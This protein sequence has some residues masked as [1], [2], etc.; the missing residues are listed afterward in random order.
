MKVKIERDEKWPVFS[1]LEV[2]D[3]DKLNRP[4]DRCFAGV[5]FVDL[6]DDIARKF[7]LIQRDYL[8]MQKSLEEF[9]DNSKT[10]DEVETSE[11]CLRNNLSEDPTGVYSASQPA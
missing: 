1:I 4:I 6:P 2:N 11:N 5:Q 10:N 3:E 8:K 9:Y 7:F